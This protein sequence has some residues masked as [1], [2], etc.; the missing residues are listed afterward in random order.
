M[1]PSHLASPKN[2][3]CLNLTGASITWSTKLEM[4]NLAYTDIDDSAIPWLV[5]QTNLTSLGTFESD[6]TE[7]GRKT[8][9]ELMPNLEDFQ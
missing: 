3:T 2:L 1:S 8:I 7:E 9:R 4:L 5:A 6:I